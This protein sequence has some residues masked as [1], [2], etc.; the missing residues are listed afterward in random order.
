[1]MDVNSLLCKEFNISLHF[2]N[3]IIKLIDDGNTIPFIAR[4]RKEATG[5]MDD[6]SLRLLSERISYIRNLEDRKK[7]IL[8]TIKELDLLT[9]DIKLSLD[10]AVTLTEVEDIYRPFK[11]KRKTKASI[12]KEKGL[13][14]LFDEII[15]NGTDIDYINNFAL[16]FLSEDHCIYDISTAIKMS[17]DIICEDISNNSESRKYI[18]EYVLNNGVLVASKKEH[19]DE[20]SKKDVYEMY[21]NFNCSIKKLNNHNILAIDRGENIGFLKVNF[22]FDENVI[23]NNISKIYCKDKT[24]NEYIEESIKSSFKRLIYPSVEREIR[25][26]LTERACSSAI[27]VFS[28]NLKQLLLQ[29]PVK[30][31]VTL[32]F[33]PAYRTGCKIAVVDS[34]GK[35]LMTDVIF[36]TAPQNKTEE[37]SKT[38]LNL[39]SKYNI[40][41]ISIGNGTAS[42]E[43]EIFI[44]NLIK[45][46]TLNVSYIIANEAGAS[47]YSASKLGSE[48]FPELD[49]SKRS[50]ISIARRIQDPL[51]ELVKIDPKSIGVGQ[52]QH[53]M[54]HKEL[55]NSLDGVVENCV[56]SVGVNINTASPSL[57]KYVSGLT[58]A[59]AKNIVSYREENGSFE[60]R[61]QLLKVSKLGEKAFLQ[62]AGFLRILDG[63]NILDRTG[64]HPESYKKTVELLNIYDLNLDTLNES[65]F[66]QKLSSIDINETSKKLNIGELTLKDIILELQKP[67]RDI[68]DSLPQPMLRQDLVDITNIKIGQQIKGTVRNVIDFGAFVDIGVHVD[69]LVHISQLSKNFVNHP[70]DVVSIGDIVTVS[71]IDVDVSKK[72]ISLSMLNE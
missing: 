70:L 16:K 38:I 67:G 13:T 36:P 22:E 34:N 60:N 28:K 30:G 44:S 7:S 56:N 61:N 49:V 19:K 52:Y 41:I 11:P 66:S 6:Q 40:E 5:N 9:D 43:S 33:D 50:A 8:S 10:N 1:M 21:H 58:S 42:K 46:N 26:S 35:M 48:E 68:R 62:C 71:V 24:S 47:V 51:A 25:S 54:P 72:R 23:L 29:P 20:S 37:A 32:G 14:P 53:D 18:R 45:E 65:E 59:T 2:L 17:L 31:K 55:S 63:P 3:S 4:Y 15:K 57:L 39:I 27:L 69:G 12:A 64:V